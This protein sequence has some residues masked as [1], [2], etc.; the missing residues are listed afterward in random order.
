MIGAGMEL[1]LV[2]RNLERVA[3]LAT[4]IGEDVVFLV[5]G[6]SIKHHAEDRGEARPLRRL[7]GRLGH[8][9]ARPAAKPGAAAAP[10]TRDRIAAI[11]VGSNSV[12]LLVAEYDPASGLSIIDELKDQP[13]LA[14]GLASTGCLD[15]AAIERALQTLARMREVC[16]RR[17]RQAHRGR[18]HRGRARGRERPWFVRRVRQELDIPLRIIDAET[19]AAL[20][21]RSVA[22]HFRLAGERTLV[23][24]I[25]GGSL[26]LI[27]AVDGLVELTVSL[28]LGAV[29]LTELHLPGERARAQGDRAAP[30]LRPEAAQARHLRPR[31]GGGH[32]HRLRRHVHEPRSH[33]AGAARPAAGRHRPRRERHRRRGRAAAST[34]SRAGRP[35]SGARCPG[36]NPER[37]DII[38][39][40]LAVTAELLDWVRSRSLTVSAFGLREG[41]LLEMAGAKE[42]SRAAIRCGCSVSSPS[43]ARATGGTSSRFATWRSSSSISSAGSSAASRRSGCCSRPRGC[44]T[45]S[46]SS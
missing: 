39:A 31:L 42:R 22:H 15:E 36:L 12:R 28:P 34:G 25:G 14:A 46:A 43:A 20:S 1:F 7:P 13:R 4:N 9:I 23:A 8:V 5:E 11:D 29:R 33:G 26:E 17:G 35:S 6:K 18:R 32:G 2:S 27:G 37:A 40:G 19:E 24:D 3:D 44:C 30:D 21:Y 16:Q 10:A 41:L 38:M 45:T